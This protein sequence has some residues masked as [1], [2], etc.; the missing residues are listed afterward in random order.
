MPNEFDFDIDS[1]EKTD[2][3]NLMV[4]VNPN[5]QLIDSHQTGYTKWNEE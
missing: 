2:D 3:P 1:E 5:T 4:V